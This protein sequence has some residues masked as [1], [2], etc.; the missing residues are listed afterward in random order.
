MKLSQFMFNLPAEKIATEPP[1]WRDECK[2]MVLNKKT[3]EIE[4]R[5]FK[6]II[7]ANYLQAFLSATYTETVNYD[8]NSPVNQFRAA[9]GLN[10]QGTINSKVSMFCNPYPFESAI[11]FFGAVNDF[12]AQK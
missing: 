2:L 11:K 3:G 7:D 12:G 4:H 8:E 5:I 10:K 9:L 6:D 1:R